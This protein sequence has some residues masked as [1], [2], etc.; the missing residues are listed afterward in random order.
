VTKILYI[1]N[2]PN[3]ADV[4]RWD[5][6]ELGYQ[7]FVARDGAEALAKAQAELPNLILLD[8]DLGPH[9]PDGWSVNVEL[10]NSERTREI[11]VVALTA[12]DIGHHNRKRALDAGFIEHLS[13]PVKP[14][15]LAQTIKT[16]LRDAPSQ[17][18]SPP[19]S[20]EASEAPATEPIPSAPS[21]SNARVRQM[22][23]DHRRAE[24]L[25]PINAIHSR[26]DSILATE[27]VQSDALL[28]AGLTKI[29]S[30][31]DR[32]EEYALHL[33]NIEHIIFPSQMFVSSAHV[34][35]HYDC[36]ICGKEYGRCGHV[37][38]RPYMGQF[39]S[40]IREGSR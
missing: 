2:D 7:V 30:A 28:H 36:S 39:C 19:Q 12:Y 17:V 32:M 27:A 9:S 16:I 38:G 34:V 24:L 10:K 22:F 26:V 5:L 21:S 14:E 15:L 8:I 6:A 29:R 1:E 37:V 33:H 31:A 3:I 13:K 25:A 23:L 20:H 40:R 18:S 4:I 35:D 11:P